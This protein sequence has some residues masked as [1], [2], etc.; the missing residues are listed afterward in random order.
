MS[1][2]RGRSEVVGGGQDDAIDPSLPINVQWFP[3]FCNWHGIPRFAGQ[4]R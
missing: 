3:V 4:E 2:S 1:V